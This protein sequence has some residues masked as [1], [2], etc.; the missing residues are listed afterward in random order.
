MSMSHDESL[1]V[2]MVETL[3]C[4]AQPYSLH[5]SQRDLEFKFEKL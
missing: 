2:A 5:N 4:V 1:I 3:I